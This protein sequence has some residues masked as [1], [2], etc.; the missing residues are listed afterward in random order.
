ML[1]EA[2]TPNT[3][4]S[5]RA[6]FPGMW[7]LDGSPW[8]YLDT[9]ATAQKPQAVIDATVRAMGVNYGDSEELRGADKIEARDHERWRKE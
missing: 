7:N 9:A 5:I 8:R 6:Q 2:I 3:G 4:G 1:A